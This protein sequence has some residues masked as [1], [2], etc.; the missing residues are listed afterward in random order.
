MNKFEYIPENKI[1]NKNTSKAYYIYKKISSLGGKKIDWMQLSFLGVFESFD[2]AEK[3]LYEYKSFDENISSGTEYYAI[4]AYT[5][6]AECEK[7]IE[8]KPKQSVEDF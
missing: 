4:I 1:Y 7:T 5:I 3:A 6:S 8:I 2:A